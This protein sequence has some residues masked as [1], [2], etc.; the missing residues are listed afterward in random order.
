MCPTFENFFNIIFVRNGVFFFVFFFF[1]G[2]GVWFFFLCFF[3]FL[4]MICKNSRD[5]SFHMFVELVEYTNI[6]FSWID[7]KQLSQMTRISRIYSR[8]IWFSWID[9]R[10]LSQTTH[11]FKEFGIPSDYNNNVILI[12]IVF[13]LFDGFF[14]FLCIRKY[15]L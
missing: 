11:I 13:G 14:F 10:Q 1:G 4:L 3:F 12:E 5:I 8:H 9:A 15:F 7:A 2:G 6:W